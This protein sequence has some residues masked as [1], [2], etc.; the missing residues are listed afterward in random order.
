MVIHI[1]IS[2]TTVFGIYELLASACKTV[3]RRI[4]VR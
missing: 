1:I 4:H 3:R 2:H